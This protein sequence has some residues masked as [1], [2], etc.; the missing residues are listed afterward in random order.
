MPRLS[1]RKS[2]SPLTVV[3]FFSFFLFEPK[4]GQV[5]G[6]VY[7]DMKGPLFPTI[8]VHSQNEDGDHDMLIPYLATE[9]WIRSLNCYIID[10]WRPWHTNGQVAGYPRTYSWLRFLSVLNFNPITVCF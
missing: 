3:L 10:D 8:A 4:N 6:T 5:V 9:A 7:K 1:S 2:V